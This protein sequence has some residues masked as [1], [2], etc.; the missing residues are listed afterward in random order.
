MQVDTLEIV[1]RSVPLPFQLD[2]EN[3]DDNVRHALPL[4]RPAPRPK[5]Q[6]N[7][8]LRGQMV[9][10]IRRVME[11][12][13]SSTSGRRSS[14]KP[15]PEGARDFLVPSRLQPGRFYAL[16]A[17][18]ADRQAAARD[19]GLRPLLPDRDLLPR[20]GSARGPRSGDHPARR[21]DGV[22]RPRIH[23]RRDGDDVV[24]V[25]RECIGVE[26]DDA[27]PAHDLRRGRPRASAPTSPTSASV[28]RSRTRPRSR[29]ARSSASSPAPSRALPRRAAGV[30]PQRARDGSRRSR[31]SG[32]RRVS[33]TSSY[34][35]TGEMRS[36]IAKFLSE[37]ELDAFAGNR[38]DIALRRGHVADRRA[39]ARRAP[40]THL[41][42]RARPARRDAWAWLLGHRLPDVRVRRG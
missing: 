9:G 12:P 7:I 10:A 19:R 29:A 15:T 27:V 28:S 3:V 37:D 39:R 4:A 1:S 14:E 22:P 8:R 11:A 26:L 31:S 35:E 18:A 41:G 13:A 23:A 25:W 42:E 2:D 32:A 5:L 36:P 6:R 17:V 21:R 24:A 20:R 16:A 33:R 40:R 34:D 30:L 38:A